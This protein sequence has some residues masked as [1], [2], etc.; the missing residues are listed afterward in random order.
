M[1]MG[2]LLQPCNLRNGNN[3]ADTEDQALFNRS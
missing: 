3:W 2:R 1:M